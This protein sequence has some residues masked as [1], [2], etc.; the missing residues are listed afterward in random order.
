[1]RNRYTPE[2]GASILP[3]LDKLKP[4]LNKALIIGSLGVLLLLASCG[5]A[6]ANSMSIEQQILA[7]EES[8]VSFGQIEDD[9]RTGTTCSGTIING[10]ETPN[11]EYQYDVLTIGHCESALENGQYAIASKTVPYTPI[12]VLG[13]EEI[14]ESAVDDNVAICTIHASEELD[15]PILPKDLIAPEESWTLGADVMTIGFA[16]YF[17]HNTFIGGLPLISKSVGPIY[18]TNIRA[19]DKNALNPAEACNTSH[20]AA[21]QSGGGTINMQTGKLVGVVASTC[22]P[23]VD[24]MNPTGML[25]LIFQATS[26]VNFR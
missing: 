2:N 7:I 26:G 24:V 12:V 6:N 25:V 19:S 21:A 4:Y 3:S 9:G 11:S 23:G 1:M 5:P 18:Q 17:N 15:I 20:T 10:Y 22:E 14:N 16:Y 8:S 13:C